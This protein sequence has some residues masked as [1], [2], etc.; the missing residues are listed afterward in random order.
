MLLVSK[1]WGPLIDVKL[2]LVV[3]HLLRFVADLLL[4]SVAV[5]RLAFGLR[6]ALVIAS[7]ARLLRLGLLVPVFVDPIVVLLRLCGYL[8]LGLLMRM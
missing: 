1:R 2:F 7:I 8:M 3:S 6:T 5:L 4:A